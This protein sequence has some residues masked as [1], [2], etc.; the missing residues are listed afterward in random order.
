MCSHSGRNK[1]ENLVA[2]CDHY[3][4]EAIV[5]EAPGEREQCGKAK[6]R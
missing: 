3:I 1:L 6:I 2:F 4:F 5:T